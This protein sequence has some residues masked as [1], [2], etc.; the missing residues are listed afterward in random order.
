MSALFRL[1]LLSAWNRS[2]SLGLTVLAVLMASTLLL[3]VE[4]LRHAARDGFAQSVSGTDLIVGARSNPLQLVLYSVFHLGEPTRMMSWASYR[5]IA[6]NPAVAWSVPLALGDSHHGY[7]VLG[8]TSAYFGL[9]RYGDRQALKLAEGRVFSGVFEA[10]IGAELAAKLGYRPGM[11]IELSH[12]DGEAHGMDHDDKPFVVVGIL[13]P[14]GTAVDRTVHVELAAIEAIHLDW[15]GGVPMPGFS[16][17]PEMLGKFDLT[18]KAISACLVGL[19]QR[20]G[21]FKL[22]RQINDFPD[23]ALTAVMPGMALDQLWQTVGVAERALQ[24]LSWLVLAVGLAGLM[25]VMLAGLSE[26]RREMAILRSV[27]AG[28]RHILGLL[29]LESFSV[30]ALGSLLGLGAVTL[31]ALLAGD[32]LAVYGVGALPVTV[33]RSEMQLLGLVLVCGL[34]V[35]LLPA[36]RAYR[37]SLADGLIP[38][39]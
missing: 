38:R 7:P 32:Q 4:R 29:M 19:H 21:V 8:T 25:A 34:L 1:A 22:Q 9:Y 27:G 30:S 23:E 16:I 26:R 24:A 11:E 17:K 36:W 20:A 13:A 6:E 31:F 12:G 10:V 35:S 18:P 37:L 14:T 39:L 2:L 15:V 3:S 28:P 33:D 5:K